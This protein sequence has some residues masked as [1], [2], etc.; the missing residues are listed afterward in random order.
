VQTVARYGKCQI[1]AV[2]ISAGFKSV[3]ST[4][5]Y[6]D[7]IV[8]ITNSNMNMLFATVREN[9][10]LPKWKNF[11]SFLLQRYKIEITVFENEFYNKSYGLV[12]LFPML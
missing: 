11:G 8:W 7:I 1:C 10:F 3:F 4:Q 2:E 9:V 12:L 5:N 6:I